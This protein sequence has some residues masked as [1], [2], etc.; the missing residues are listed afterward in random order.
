MFTKAMLRLGIALLVV[1]VTIIS[2]KKTPPPTPEP[3]P[4]DDLFKIGS[5]T[6]MGYEVNLWGETEPFVGYNELYVEVVDPS[7]NKMVSNM[8]IS[9]MPMMDMGTMMH[10][11]PMES[12]DG[13]N[14]DGLYEGAV[15]FI[16][17]STAGT[18]SLSV[19]LS[20]A[21]GQ[22]ETV[23]FAP[24][25]KAPAEARM[26]TFEGDINQEKL[27]VSLVKPMKP[28]VGINDYEITVHQRQTMMSFPGV[29]NYSITIEPEMPTMGHGSPDN[30]DPVS[31]GNGHYEGKV[32]FTM[33]GLWR[34]HM[35]IKDGAD[36]V[37]SNI[38]FDITF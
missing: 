11:A 7:T 25:V 30:E 27:F 31:S 23:D 35:T 14:S 26:L 24:D 21:G 10:S 5:G 13:P 12:P 2:C 18:W 8:D 34:V 9:F 38:H 1:S 4:T 17:P 15:V 3:S 32:N 33:T 37:K 6:A 20:E 28:E 19:E 29:D 36:T 16:M 22:P